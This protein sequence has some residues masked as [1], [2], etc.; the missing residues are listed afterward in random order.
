MPQLFSFEQDDLASKT[1]PLIIRNLQV[2]GSEFTNVDSVISFRLQNLLMQ[3]LQLTGNKCNSIILFEYLN[4]RAVFYMERPTVAENEVYKWSTIY[5]RQAQNFE[6]TGYTAGT[7][8]ANNLKHLE[9]S[10]GTFRSNF[11]S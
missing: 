9:V 8:T 1:Q 11:V 6:L 4:D 2:T 7:A 10:T 3:D 5:T